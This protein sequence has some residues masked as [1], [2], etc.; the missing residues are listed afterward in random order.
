MEPAGQV[1][2]EELTRLKTISV[3]LE[4]TMAEQMTTTAE[5]MGLIT[6]TADQA[7]L[8]TTTADP[9]GIESTTAGQKPTKL[10]QAGL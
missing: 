6:T 5:Q 9:A 7:E 10:E 8:E 4:S 1:A 2:R 3:E